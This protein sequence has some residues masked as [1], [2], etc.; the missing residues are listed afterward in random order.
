[1]V[2]IELGLLFAVHQGYSDIHFMVKS[3]NQG[4]IHAIEGGKSRS[5]EQNSVLQRITSLLARHKIWVLS[6]YVPSLDNLADRP[7]CSLPVPNY[8]RAT[9]TFSI[10]PTPFFNS[11]QLLD[12]TARLHNYYP[13]PSFLQLDMCSL[14]YSSAGAPYLPCHNTTLSRRNTSTPPQAVLQPQST[15]I[16][17]TPNV[18]RSEERRV[19][20]ECA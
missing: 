20:K 5:P 16:L 7:S 9:S 4:V 6:S 15:V 12:T 11:P 19:G 3:D 18:Y 10:P 2:A 14:V 17:S 13:L 1:M 8:P